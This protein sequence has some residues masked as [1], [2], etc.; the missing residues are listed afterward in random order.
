MPEMLQLTKY[1]F[2]DAIRLAVEKL[3][4]LKYG[5]SVSEAGSVFFSWQIT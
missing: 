4:Y 2:I 5:M 1:D 3:D